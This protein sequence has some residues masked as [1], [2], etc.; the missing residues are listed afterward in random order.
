MRNRYKHLDPNYIYFDCEKI[1]EE[2]KCT[3]GVEKKWEKRQKRNNCERNVSKDNNCERKASKNNKSADKNASKKTQTRATD[4]S[5]IKGGEFTETTDCWY[6][7]VRDQYQI[8][9]FG[10]ISSK[11]KLMKPQEMITYN[12]LVRLGTQMD[13][14][15]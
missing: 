11:R 10:E 1:T 12:L 14:H 9:E 4:K 13:V 6:S 2:C 15:K 5:I 7:K 8:S 3:Y